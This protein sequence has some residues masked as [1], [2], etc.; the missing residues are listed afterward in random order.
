MKPVLVM[1][2]QII[3]D[4]GEFVVVSFTGGAQVREGGLQHFAACGFLFF[5]SLG[6]GGKSEGAN[7]SRK[8]E[9]LKN[10]GDEDNAEGEKD[11]QVAPSEGLAIC[12]HLRERDGCGQRDYAAHSGPADDQDA[13]GFGKETFLAKNGGTNESRSVGPGKNPSETQK[14]YENTEE[15]TIEEQLAHAVFVDAGEDVGQLQADQDEN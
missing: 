13:S 8:G 11:N 10:E 7:K 9:P 12:E 14:N 2:F 4:G 3:V 15:R 6:S 5:I 1:V